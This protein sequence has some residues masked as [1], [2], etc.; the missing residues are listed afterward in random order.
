MSKKAKLFDFTVNYRTEL[1]VSIL[2]LYIATAAEV[3]TTKLISYLID[4]GIQKGD[5][6]KI[7]M[8]AS[9]VLGLILITF[10]VSVIGSILASKSSAGFA[11]NMREMLFLKVQGFSFKNADKFSNAS[12][13]VRMTA[14][15]QNIQNA[16][17]M[18]IRVLM[19]TP[20][21]LPFALIMAFL[22]H[23]GL[24][25]VLVGAMVTLTIVLFLILLISF[26]RFAKM[27]NETDQL[28]KKIKENILGIKTI[29]AFVKEDKEYELFKYRTQQVRKI[30]NW[31]QNFVIYFQ[32][33]VTA[34]LLFSFF[35]IMI[36]TANAV[37]SNSSDIT[38]GVILTFVGYLFQ[39]VF[40]IVLTTVVF[41]MVAIAVPSWRRIKEVFE[42]RSEIV[43]I[44]NPVND[45]KSG[46]ISFKNVFLKYDPKAEN[47]VLKNI[48]L[49]IQS[50][51]TIGIIGPT[52]S[53]KSSIV[54]LIPRLY[55]VTEGSI[56]IDGIDIRNYD[57]KTLRDNVSIVLQNNLLFKGTIRE[58]MLWGNEK[59]TDEEINHA[60]KIACAYDFV[61]EKE[62]NLDYMVEEKGSNFSGGQ[63]QRLSIARAL[64][65]KPKIIILDDSTS[66]V[67]NNTDKKI[68]QAFANDLQ[69]VTKIIIAQRISS[70]QS[71]DKIAVMKAGR[72]VAFDT[73]ENL[74][75]NN[76]FYSDLYESQKIKEVE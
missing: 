71:A 60:L 46:S 52:A 64:M 62:N 38:V 35:G 55:D 54:N 45:V 27:I 61:Y 11:K 1:F 75:K 8:Y 17:F 31:A 56:E 24:A 25:W 47:N 14:D 23:S 76:E 42:E 28:N 3:V 32:P 33:I 36:Y 57:L 20:F 29:K 48:D 68:R 67:D 51:Q 72:V 4:Q 66:A 18:V 30:S 19:R 34:M 53:G 9:I 43:N 49:E 70:I 15:V 2:L 44:E 40:A 10:T 26:P 59:G 74:I 6:A 63:K 58:N 21:I 65:K 37:T 69:D 50:G 73:H 41:I 39:V 5:T 16:Y 12:L 7:W 13:L 22:T